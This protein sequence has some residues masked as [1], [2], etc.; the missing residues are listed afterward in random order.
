MNVPDNSWF[1]IGFGQ[2]MYDTDM[3]LWQA[4]GSNSKAMDLYSTGHSTPSMQETQNVPSEQPIVNAAN[5]T[6]SFITTRDM[7]TGD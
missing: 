6:V 2:D 3:I 5:S 4:S 1:S 7:D